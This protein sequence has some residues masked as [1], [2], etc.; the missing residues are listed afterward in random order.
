MP[1]EPVSMD[2]KSLRPGYCE[3]TQHRWSNLTVVHCHIDIA[4]ARQRCSHTLLHFHIMKVSHEYQGISGVV[5]IPTFSIIMK[6]RAV[7]SSSS[8]SSVAYV[9]LLGDGID[10]NVQN[11]WWHSSMWGWQLSSRP[12][13]V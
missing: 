3:Q 8:P 2:G 4:H 5:D 1:C 7:G 10:R 9:M 6:C 13:S 11:I 12:F